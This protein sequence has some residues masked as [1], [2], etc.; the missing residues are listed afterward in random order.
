LAAKASP[1]GIGRR[2]PGTPEAADC[3]NLVAG[4][5]IELREHIENK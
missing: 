4:G 1:G 5:G 3:W 2:Q